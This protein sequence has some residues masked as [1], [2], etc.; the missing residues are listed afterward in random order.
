VS[1]F[2]TDSD[3]LKHEFGHYMSKN[4]VGANLGAFHIDEHGLSPHSGSIDEGIADYFACSANDDAL[5]GEA[6]LGPLSVERD[7]K[8]FS[9]VCPDDLI[10][11]VHADGEIIASFAWSLRDAY[12][13]E[14]ADR[15]VLGALSFLPEGGSFVD[16][17]QGIIAASGEA[18]SSGA[19]P[20]SE[21]S[22]IE[23]LIKD[24]GLDSCG[25]EMSLQGDIERVLT[26]A[27]A[28]GLAKANDLSCDE[29]VKIGLVWPGLFH[30]YRK[31]QL[32][33]SALSWDFDLDVQGDSD[34]R[35]EVFIRKGDH[36]T[37]RTA[38]NT[39][40]PQP[41]DFDARFVVSTSSP[42][43]VLDAASPYLF[44]PGAKYYIAIVNKSC[45]QVVVRVSANNGSSRAVPV[46]DDGDIE[47]ASE[48][49][50]E[51]ISGFSCRASRAQPRHSSLLV[52]AVAVA[53]ALR[54]RLSSANKRAIRPGSE[55][56][57]PNVSPD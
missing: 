23:A 34:A 53:L 25:P 22:V 8:D 29:A 46:D 18:V 30:F 52:V 7:L 26:I 35:L 6:S 20:E 49:T 11:E 9:K 4:A 47:T 24:R 5:F 10:G 32:E 21:M 50:I 39:L 42:R 48:E 33:D 43:I 27:G 56:P 45:D 55:L 14:V 31:T 16:F 37:F 12:G 57:H 41:E 54:R 15:I 36:V 3:I 1:D 19:L 38:Q 13:P 51:I 17:A 28:A 40:L 44:E 2:A